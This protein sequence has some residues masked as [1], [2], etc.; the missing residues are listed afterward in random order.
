MQ[1]YPHNIPSTLIGSAV[2]ASSTITGSFINNFSALPVNTASVALNITGSRGTDG[3]SVVVLGPK[4]TTG[5]RGVTGF[6]GNNI[7]LLSGSWHSGACAA[8]PEACNPFIFYPAF[9][10]GG[11]LQCDFSDFNQT[12]YSTDLNF[13]VDSSIMYYND[14]CTNI[15]SN[16]NPLGAFDDGEVYATDAAGVISVLGS[17][18]DSSGGGGGGGG[19]GGEEFEE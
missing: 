17:C 3:T 5:P 13:T 1:F 10:F 7:L 12:Y 6:R 16:A 14:I 15:V 19:G 8:V 11:E 4:G 18:G 9:T 2:S